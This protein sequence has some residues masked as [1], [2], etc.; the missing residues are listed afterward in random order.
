MTARA[1]HLVPALGIA[2]LAGAVAW[3]SF[4]QEPARAFLFP[5]VISVA[6]VALALWNLARAATGLS[7]VGDGVPWARLAALLPGLAVAL[8]HG[9]W[10]AKTLGFYTASA[11]AVLVLTTLYDP[12]PLT[13]P[14]GWLR[15]IAVT[16][17]VM[18][19]V[20][21]L[22][23]LLLEVQTPRGAFI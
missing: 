17:A 3:L 8:V 14:R 20:Y 16:A 11:A 2:G 7:K 21:A 5:R 23:A 1:Q 15:R 10:A 6:F 18:A 4:T 19:V 22:F 13:D 9:L 12:T